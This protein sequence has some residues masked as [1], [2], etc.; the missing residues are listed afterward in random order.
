MT[1]SQSVK[2]TK[3]GGLRGYDAGNRVM[4][5]KRHAMV[6][7]AGRGSVMDGHPASVKDRDGGLPLLCTSSRRWP[8]IQLSYANGAYASD[9]PAEARPIRLE[10]VRKASV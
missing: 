10:I 7:T 2:T 1:D 3:S 5:R 4:G 8:F 9:R 6:D